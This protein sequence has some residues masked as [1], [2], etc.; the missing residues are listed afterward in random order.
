[1]NF[2]SISCLTKR[3]GLVNYSGKQMLNKKIGSIQSLE[4]FSTKRVSIPIEKKNEIVPVAKLQHKWNLFQPNLKSPFLTKNDSQ[5]LFSN[6]IQS[7]SLTQPLQT[8]RIIHISKIVP[9]NTISVSAKRKISTTTS[10]KRFKRGGY[11]IALLIEMKS[12]VYSFY[13]SK[14]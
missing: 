11:D 13:S 3:H 12:N 6:T 14:N 9:F 5:R 2:N 7:S 8:I 1:M 10:E 4:R